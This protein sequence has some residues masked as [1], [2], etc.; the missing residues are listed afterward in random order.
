MNLI[1]I[2]DSEEQK[3]KQKIEQD[4]VQ[5]PEQVVKQ[6]AGQAEA[7]AMK[8]DVMQDGV[9]A[10]AQNPTQTVNDCVSEEAVQDAEH[11]VAQEVKQELEQDA[12]QEV[13]PAGG[14]A[15]RL[16]PKKIRPALTTI[17]LRVTR[18][19]KEALQKLAEARDMSLGEFFASIARSIVAQATRKGG[20]A[21]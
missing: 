6:D 3:M 7:Q 13:T 12:P 14:P 20:E 19:E 21:A 11:E 4:G 2:C 15:F 18:K 10:D 1:D 9:Q 16:P 17:S 8:H 5:N